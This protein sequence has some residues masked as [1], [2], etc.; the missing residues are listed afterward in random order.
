MIMVSK[1]PARR[2]VLSLFFAVFVAATTPAMRAQP[3]PGHLDEVLREM[4]AASLKFQSA[5]ADFRW[6]FYEKVVKE[7]STQTGTIYFK[8]DGTST[9]MGAKVVSPAI[10]FIEYRNGILRLFAPGQNHLTQINGT[11]NKAQLESFLTVGFGG[12]GKDLASAWTISDLGDETVDG[13]KTAKLDLVAKDPAVR[14]NF[15]HMTIW[16]D[17]VR[18]LDLK[19]SLYMPSGDYRT[20]VYTNIKYNQKKLDEKPYQFKTD[21][22]TTIDQ[23]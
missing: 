8:K 1:I 16:V 20:A 2:V 10:T 9:V 11:K 4:D 7:T 15:T 21:K 12:S 22:N 13:V 6:D 18:G 14:N 3:K 23:H 5:E 19:Q 17:P